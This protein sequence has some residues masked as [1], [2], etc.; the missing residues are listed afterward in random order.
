VFV[1][2]GRTDVELTA[3]IESTK[4][5]I[6]FYASTPEYRGV[7]E[8]SGFGDLQ[9]ELTTLSKEGRWAEMGAAIPDELLQEIAVVGDPVSVGPALV[10]RWG[11]VYD[12]LVLDTP[13]P[14]GPDVLADVATGVRATT[15]GRSTGESRS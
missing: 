7:L 10:E 4:Q 8:R 9:P 13:Y 1:V 5:R 14:V 3:A 6:A 15:A 11:H 2:V 12:R